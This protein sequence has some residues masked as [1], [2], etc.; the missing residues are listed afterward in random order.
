MRKGRT[1]GGTE[2]TPRR[3]AGSESPAAKSVY[4]IWETGIVAP[5]VKSQWATQGCARGSFRP[6]ECGHSSDT[7]AQAELG[8]ATLQTSNDWEGRATGRQ[9]GDTGAPPGAG[10]RTAFLQTAL[11]RPLSKLMTRT[12]NP[13]T[14]SK[15]IRPPPTCKLKPRS[16]KIRRTTKMVQ[17]MSTSCA[18]SRAHKCESHPTSA[19]ELLRANG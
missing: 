16:H 12:T 14:S 5:E 9:E 4:A 3:S 13:T 10:T 17:S 19:K 1:T 18:H 8:R 2:E 11:R 7:P 6:C 15:W